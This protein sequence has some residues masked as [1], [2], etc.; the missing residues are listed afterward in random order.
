MRWG[1]GCMGWSSWLAERT[2]GIYA[3][4]LVALPT[5]YG[6]SEVNGNSESFP[7]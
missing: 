4:T 3:F 2:Y 5:K 7:K 1:G 6:I